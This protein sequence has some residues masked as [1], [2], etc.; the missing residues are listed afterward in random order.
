MESED[1]NYEKEFAVDI[2]SPVS[3][4]M[5]MDPCLLDGQVE[6]EIED[7]ILAEEVVL[8]SEKLNN[9]TVE[10]DQELNQSIDFTDVLD[11]SECAQSCKSPHSNPN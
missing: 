11:R 2:P 8:F 10:Q 5:S 3:Q 4:A 6:D 7:N 1:E 9:S